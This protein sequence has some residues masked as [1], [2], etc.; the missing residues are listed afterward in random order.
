MKSACCLALLLILLTPAARADWPSWRGDVR[1]SG[2]ASAESLPREWSPDQ[3]VLWRVELPEP[4]NSTPIVIGDRVFVT[5]P[6]TKEHWRGLM[7][8]DRRDGKLLWKQGLVY[9]REEPTHRT[10]HYCSASPATDGSIVVAAYGSAGV[11]AY[12]MDGK[13]LWHRDFGPISHVWGNSTS[14]ILHGDLCIHYHGPGKGAFLAALDKKTGTTVWTW[15]EP[16]WQPKERTDGF[17]GQGDG[18]IG[19]CST[20][21]VVQAN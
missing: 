5:Q 2:N 21:S 9:D 7:C 15:H 18:V 8:F 12:D 20:P 10:N 4:G 11:V 17:S 1:G 6:V 3:N 14:P 16:D 13:Q 19:S